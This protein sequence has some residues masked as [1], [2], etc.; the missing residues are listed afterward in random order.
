MLG[1]RVELERSGRE[2]APRCG[3]VL[4]VE[5]KQRRVMDK[6]G[7]EREHRDIDTDVEQQMQNADT[8]CSQGRR[9]CALQCCHRV[10]LCVPVWQ[11]QLETSVDFDV[12]REEILM[13]SFLAFRVGSSSLSA[14]C[15]FVLVMD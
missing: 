14:N 6:F 10:G 11:Q 9:C 12:A 3:A 8:F 7:R 1:W 4:M 2:G 15:G 5:T 13:E